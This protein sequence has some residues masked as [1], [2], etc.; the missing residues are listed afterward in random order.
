MSSVIPYVLGLAMLA[1][2]GVLFA[3]IVSFAFGARSDRTLGTKLMTA[4]VVL[5]GVAIAVFAVMMLLSLA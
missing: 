1:T 5:Q 3:G 4:R 2:A